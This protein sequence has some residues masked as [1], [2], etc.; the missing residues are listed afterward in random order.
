LTLFCESI[1]ANPW[2]RHDKAWKDFMSSSTSSA[3]SLESDRNISEEMLINMLDKLLLPADAFERVAI[4]KDE[5]TAVEKQ[6]K[7]I[8]SHIAA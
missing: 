1:V 8:C 3:S 4:L 2:L 6:R 7:F 5:V